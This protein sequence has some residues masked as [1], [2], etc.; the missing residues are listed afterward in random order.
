[1]QPSDTHHSSI[2]T[3][4]AVHGVSKLSRNLVF[5]ALLAARATARTTVQFNDAWRYILGDEPN[6]PQPTCPVQYPIAVSVRCD[7]L[8]SLGTFATAAGCESAACSNQYSLYQW[9]DPT[10]GCASGDNSSCWAGSYDD[11]GISNAT[12][13]GWVSAATNSSIIPPGPGPLPPPVCPGDRACAQFDDSTWR[14]VQT[15]HDYVVEGTPVP[16]ADR[17]HGYLPFNFSW[18][19]KHFTVDADWSGQP[20]WLDFDGV[21]RASDYFL[22]GVWVGHW[23]SG[24]SP[25]RWYIHNVSGAPLNYGG[26]DN[27][28]AVRVDGVT[29]NEGWFYE[30]SGINREVTINTAPSVNL[31]PWGIYAPSVVTGAITGDLSGPQTA[32]SA[33]IDATIDVQN[34][35]AVGDSYTL[36]CAVVDASGA[37]VATGTAVGSPLAPAAWNRS[38]VTIT[39]SSPT[40]WSPSNPYLYTFTTT[41]TATNLKT[42]DSVNVTIGVRSAIFNSNQGLILNGFPLQIKGFSQHQDFGGLG[43]A[44]PH[45]VQRYRVDSL[46][47]LGFNG[48]RTAH[49]PVSSHLLDLTDEL[50]VLVMAENRN[51]E[52]QV[53]GGPFRAPVN[54]QAIN[55]STFPDPQY[56]LEASQMVLRDRNHPSIIM[57]A[58]CSLRA[59]APRAGGGGKLTR[60]RPFPHPPRPPQV[61]AV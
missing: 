11:C 55:M 41:L 15:P 16:T 26:A 28:L 44:V 17:N 57:C 42:V 59:R 25:F 4:S 7:G 38:S 48:W 10:T 27:V 56:L 50:G 13:T 6:W 51:L 8:S 3:P 52:R 21:Y 43:T 31:V 18:Y 58:V 60:A 54:P 61:V 34:S 35:G 45:R 30:G 1:V 12:G 37:I 9:C 53:I 46:L 47:N 20:V 24:Y 40:L 23:E 22:N 5:A 2:I 29:H 32:T 36:S 14:S 33:V 19:R 39:L 49:N